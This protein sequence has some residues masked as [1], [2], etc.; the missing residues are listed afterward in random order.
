MESTIYLQNDVKKL[1]NEELLL[2]NGGSFGYDLGFFLRELVIYVSNGG[3]GPGNV[4]V[5][6]D[7]GLNYK[8]VH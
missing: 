5:G 4:A 1:T 3:N 7:L 2:I 8:P 6:V